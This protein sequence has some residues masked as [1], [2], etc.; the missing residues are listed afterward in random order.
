MFVN[1]LGTEGSHVVPSGSMMMLC[2]KQINLTILSDF[3]KFV[4]MATFNNRH[5]AVR[6]PNAH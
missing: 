5:L 6:I 1:F 2:I 3:L 4:R